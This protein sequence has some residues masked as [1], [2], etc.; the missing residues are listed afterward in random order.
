MRVCLRECLGGRGEGGEGPGD[1][2]RR[3]GGEGGGRADST[4]PT[5]LTEE[6]SHSLTRL[7]REAPVFP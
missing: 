4:F 5:L 1:V 6:C 3:L 2:G 7:Y